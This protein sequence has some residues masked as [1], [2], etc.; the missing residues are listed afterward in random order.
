MILIRTF[1][2]NISHTKSPNLERSPLRIGNST[3]KREGFLITNDRQ[4]FVSVLSLATLDD[5]FVR[6]KRLRIG[7]ILLW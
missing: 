4:M 5:I 6:F 3:F 7:S 2:S 1:L